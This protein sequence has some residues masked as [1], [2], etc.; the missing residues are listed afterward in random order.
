VRD[1]GPSHA[2]VA[3]DANAQQVPKRSTRPIGVD[4][5]NYVDMKYP[6]FVDVST[7]VQSFR[8]K[9]VGH[10]QTAEGLA[11]AGFFHVGPEDNVRCFQCGGG[12]KNW[13]PTDDPWTEHAR[14]FPRCPFLLANKEQT[15]I[16]DSQTPTA[17]SQTCTKNKSSPS[18]SGGQLHIHDSPQVQAALAMGFQRDLIRQVV[19][20][21]IALTGT[22]FP[23][24]ESLLEAIF[25][26]QEDQ[27]QQVHKLEERSGRRQLVEERSGRRQSVHERQQIHGRNSTSEAQCSLNI[28]H[29]A[30]DLQSRRTANAG[31]L[32]DLEKTRETLDSGTRGQLEEN[33]QLREARTCKVCMDRDVD[34]VFLPCGHLVCCSNCSPAL[35][36]CAICRALIRGTVKV[37]LS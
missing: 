35:R 2:A 8:S 26:L 30:E 14:W 33:R 5:I 28:A 6:T 12:L 21:R 29:T 19:D 7:R 37:F 18:S 10:G 3:T 36:N 32:Q 34:T 20:Q 13:K 24:V 4:H 22:D 31:G 17:A 23:N 25:Q 11:T 27:Q 16:E 15:F 9:L 1:S